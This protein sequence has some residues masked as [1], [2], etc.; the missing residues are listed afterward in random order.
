MLLGVAVHRLWPE[1]SESLG[2]SVANARLAERL[3]FDHVIA[4]SHVLR[5]SVGLSLDPVVLLSAVAGA[6]S[7]IRMVSSVLIAPLYHP[8][9]VAHQ[10]ASLDLLSDGRFVLGVGTG[11]D[12]EEF[13]ALGVP[14]SE[15]GRRTNEALAAV[16]ELWQGT[17][18][19][20]KLGVPPVT[21]GGPPVWVGGSSD[22]AFRRALRFGQAWYGSGDP[23]SVTAARS[24]IGELAEDV[25]RD[26]ASLGTTV[27]AFLVPPGFRQVGP[28]PGRLLGGVRPTPGSVLDELQ[29]LR[30]TG[31]TA[32]S[33]WSPV[34]AEA[35]PDVMAWAA[36]ELLPKVTPAEGVA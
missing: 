28:S 5:G 1:D 25:G 6:T 34:D 13:R 17:S 27:V 10:A 2:G 23:A 15:R 7:R 16:R 9:V 3:G 12:A 4:G 22:P 20:G 24:R 36:E 8:V 26:P 35:L 33:L 14:F 32:C 29:Q 19:S 11:W 30:E 18:P 21:P 31:V